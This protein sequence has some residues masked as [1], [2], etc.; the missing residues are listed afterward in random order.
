MARKMIRQTHLAQQLGEN[1]MWLSRRLRGDRAFDLDDLQRIAEILDCRIRD[2][3]PESA[4][5][6]GA[7]DRSRVTAP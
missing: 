4:L 7:Q 3:M 1:D 6:A 2:L 5:D